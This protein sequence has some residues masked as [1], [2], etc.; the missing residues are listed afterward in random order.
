MMMCCGVNEDV[1]VKDDDDQLITRLILHIR[2]YHLDYSLEGDLSVIGSN[3]TDSLSDLLWD[4]WLL[5]CYGPWWSS[6]YCVWS[7]YHW[8]F[9]MEER[10]YI[11]KT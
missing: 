3:M 2:F 4:G 7:G 5:Q 9:V 10:K 8:L 1:S 6:W 11:N